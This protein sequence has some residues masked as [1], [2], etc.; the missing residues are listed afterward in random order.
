MKIEKKKNEKE[1]KRKKKE[2]KE[3]H[4]E[5]EVLQWWVLHAVPQF[6]FESFNGKT[7][8]NGDTSRIYQL[9]R[10]ISIIE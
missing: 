6:M 5:R 8:V 4:I 10:F 2:K 1:K 9:L 3:R 7:P